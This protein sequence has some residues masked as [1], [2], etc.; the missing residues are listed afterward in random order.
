MCIMVV[1]EVTC[2]TVVVVVE[3]TCGAVV[4]VVVLRLCLPYL[5]HIALW[6]VW[7]RDGT[8]GVES[9]S[10]EWGCTLILLDLGGECI[11]VLVALVVL[12]LF[13]SVLLGIMVVLLY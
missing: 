12:S 6:L 11:V 5:F 3:M 1:V 7:G 13:D 10:I 8:A 2:G 9:S 4:V